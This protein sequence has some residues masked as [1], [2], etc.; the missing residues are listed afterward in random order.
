MSEPAFSSNPVSSNLEPAP[1]PSRYH[2]RAVADPSVL[3][4]VVEQFVLRDLIPSHVNCR[5]HAADELRIELEVVGLAEQ[6][7]SHVA[8]R[9]RGIPTVT[10][11]LL[12]RA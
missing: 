1:V 9:L 7:A 8:R 11:V 3:S 4:R 5:R 6:E 2:V 10:G 12:Q